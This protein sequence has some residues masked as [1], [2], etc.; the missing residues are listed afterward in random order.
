MN[1]ISGASARVGTQVLSNLF[2]GIVA[3]PD[4][5]VSDLTL[6][7][8]EVT[9][10]ALF[11]ACRGRG[12]GA[13]QGARH[14]IEFAAQATERGARVVVYETPTGDET[15]AQEAAKRLLQRV[16]QRADQD[17]GQ[18]VV[19]VPD[20]RTHL[21]VIADRFFGQPSR[22]LQLVGVTGTNGKT[23]CAWLIAQALSLCGR[24]A[25][26]IG[27][28]GFGT[29]GALRPVAHTTSDVV[30]VHRQLATLRSD[31]AQAVAMEVSSHALDQGRVDEVR[32]AAAA[33]T[34]LTQDHLDYHGTLE[35]YGAAKARL[36][37][38]STLHSRVINVDD[39]FGRELAA[40][41]GAPGRLVVT[42]RLTRSP[43]Y[44]N[45]AAHVTAMQV[46]MLAD[47]FELDLDSS[48]GS[49]QLRVPLIGEFNVDN[50]LTTLAVLLATEVPLAQAVAALGQCEAAPGR[51]QTVAVAG[52]AP[53]ATVIVDYA[54]T[55][56]ALGKALDA[57]RAHTRGRLHV[58][59]GC[60]GDRDVLKRP[61]MGRIAAAKAD[62]VT[63][64]DDNPRTEDPQAI[65]RDILAGIPGERDSV[66]LEH[67]RAIAIRDAIRS[68]APRDLVLIAGKG[69]EDYQIHGTARRPF[70][71]VQV[72]R[73]VLES[74]P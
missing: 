71:D 42:R 18:F 17:N 70:S 58:V 13:G 51:M 44:G 7:S 39:A 54:H 69:H 65:V 10:G 67:D 52:A 20:L 50:A 41:A 31:G 32:F 33:F 68:A 61:I 57:A 4:I 11:L 30:S 64:T 56:D 62:A 46:R 74:A 34:N 35:A 29:A 37:A 8:R 2:A 27:T 26:Y 63:V 15:R 3:T 40:T 21:G 23:T 6:D 36:F 48:W 60:G 19:A 28:L 14:G 12:L 49:A 1:A 53:H 66:L 24:P 5:S 59:F 45:G 47:G 55:P 22:A 73:A 16:R 9:P 72:A 38:R 43:S 25:A